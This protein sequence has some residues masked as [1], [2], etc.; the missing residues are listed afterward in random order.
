M[1]SIIVPTKDRED[2]LLKCIDSIVR[3]S[4]KKWELIV[5]DQNNKSNIQQYILNL[6]DKRI[7]YFRKE[8]H[9]K[10]I[11]L[12]F[13]VKRAKGE[14]TTFTDDDCVADKDWIR[15]IKKA[16]QI[17]PGA[18]MVFGQ[19][20]PYKKSSNKGKTCPSVFNIKKTSIIDHFCYHAK[21]IGFGN[22]MS[23]KKSTFAK[24]GGFSQLLGPGSLG[25]AAEDA[26]I[27][28]RVIENNMTI[29]SSPNPIVYHNRWLTKTQF[30]K[31][32]LSYTCGEMACYGNFAIR[33]TKLAKTVVH[34]NIKRLSALYMQSLKLIKN[35]PLNKQGYFLLYRAIVLN[36]YV[37]RGVIAAASLSVR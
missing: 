9:S 13:A 8:I 31:L 30:K 5:V 33:G 17:H 16:F 12:N 20:L 35:T 10:S 7:R 18:S 14:I 28:L 26:E 22:N 15:N 27:S 37:V 1:I 36:F 24:V 6:H 23:I 25:I 19:T 29:L 34:K 4:E 11:A 2:A 21:K 3:Q 32:L